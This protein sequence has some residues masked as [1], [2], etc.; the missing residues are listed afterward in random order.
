MGLVQQGKKISI[1]GNINFRDLSI[2]SMPMWHRLMIPITAVLFLVAT[3]SGLVLV[4][5]FGQGDHM[6]MG[7]SMNVTTTDNN[8]TSPVIYEI[9]DTTVQI[10]LSW[11]P[12]AINTNDT[13]TFTFEF[14][15]SDTEQRLQNVS[16][17]VHMS[18]N[19]RS[20]GHAHEGAAPEGIGTLEQQ[21]D[22]QGSLSMIVESIKVG[23][24]A[25]DGSAQF[26]INVMPE[27]PLA[28]VMIAGVVLSGM[29]AASRIF[30]TK[31]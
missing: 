16:Y 25:I 21:F 12:E 27:F 22:S 6:Q 11:Q 17:S 30:K 10:K 4:Q 31:L 29:V 8:Q 15:D 24:S 20:M 9:P 26:S 3:G 2:A 14:I 18:L 28:P 1:N 23:D 7:D 19:G 13:T 5:A